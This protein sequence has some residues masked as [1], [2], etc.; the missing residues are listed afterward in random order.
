[1]MESVCVYIYIYMHGERTNAF[2]R[3]L[4]SVMLEHARR[5]GIGEERRRGSRAVRCGSHHGELQVSFACLLI[6]HETK[7]IRFESIARRGKARR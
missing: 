4:R 3:F 1:M 7:T 2:D 6:E 5:V